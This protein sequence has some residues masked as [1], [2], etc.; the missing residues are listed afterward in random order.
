MVAKARAVLA[1]A[2]AEGIKIATAESCTGGLV[3]ACLTEVPG[4][5]SVVDR[6]FVTYTNR[7]KVEELGVAD[8]LI[9][10][11]GA[12]SEAVAVAM[13]AG[14]LEHS[15]A[16]IAVAVTG[17]AG[18]GGATPAKPIG[19]VHIAAQ[20]RDGDAVHEVHEFGDIGRGPVRMKSVAAALDLIATLIEA[21]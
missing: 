3:I 8:E 15:R 14:A 9:A 21:D 2:G 1:A 18:P 10:A 13:A 5:S 12:V 4:A 19:T 6:G 17:I 16:D 20:R 7:S 11:F